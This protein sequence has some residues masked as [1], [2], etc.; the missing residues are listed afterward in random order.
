MGAAAAGDR[1]YVIPRPANREVAVFERFTDTSRRAVVIA[2]HETHRLGGN[3]IGD[4][5]LLIGLA[6]ESRGVC[7]RALTGIGV[8]LDDLRRT[9]A[10]RISEGDFAA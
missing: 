2:N 3:I 8:D 1:P 4:V 9:G 7:H 10:R 6:K 5:E